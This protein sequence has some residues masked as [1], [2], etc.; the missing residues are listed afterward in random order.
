[1]AP[2]SLQGQ[3]LQLVI[4]VIGTN[5]KLPSFLRLFGLF[6]S[7]SF[8]FFLDFIEMFPIL[9]HYSVSVVKQNIPTL[10][11]DQAACL[12]FKTFWGWRERH[13]RN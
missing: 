13:I 12:M 4:F 2:I 1:M 6:S 9:S 11:P 5:I 10:I 3:H 7:I 8:M